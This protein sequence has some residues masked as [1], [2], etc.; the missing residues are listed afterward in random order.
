M[1]ALISEIIT[2]IFKI[3]SVWDNLAIAEG[4]II[5]ININADEPQSQLVLG[6]LS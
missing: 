1:N 4:S 2:P 3:I 6:N 5:S